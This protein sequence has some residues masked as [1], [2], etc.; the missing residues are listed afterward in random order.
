[1]GD[2]LNHNKMPING[3]GQDMCGCQI[4]DLYLYLSERLRNK[5]S[6]DENGLLIHYT[7]IF[8]AKKNLALWISFHGKL[9]NYHFVMV[10]P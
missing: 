5:L 8:V 6:L 1:M 2:S 3:Q 7:N 9:L 4:N 10:S